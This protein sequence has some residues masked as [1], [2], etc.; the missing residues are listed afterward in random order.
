MPTSKRTTAPAFQF[1]PSDFLGSPEVHAMSLTE[2]GA[3]IK[4]LGFCWDMDGLPTDHN[5]LASMLRIPR[6]RFDRLWKGPLGDCFQELSGKYR[7][8]RLDRERYKQKSYARRQSD[9]AKSRWNKDRG[10]ATALPPKKSGT[11]VAMLSDL[12]S[13][14]PTSVPT[15]KNVVGTA[16]AQ[17][18]I[19]RRRMDAAFEY[20]RL[21]VPQ[22]AHTDLSALH[23]DGFNLFP[24]Y[25]RVSEDWTNGAHKDDSPGAD[26]IKFWK[27]RHDEEWPPAVT[28][29]SAK[30]PAWAR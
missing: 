12:Q 29:A 10:D 28:P 16:R 5:K 20:G 7:N 18:L 4:L 25:E 13:P 15:T 27:A 21:Y 8:G 11:P 30:V 23:P 1:Y 17:S 14:S 3:Y 2:V 9:N 19:A 24:W 26:M 22:R 6:S